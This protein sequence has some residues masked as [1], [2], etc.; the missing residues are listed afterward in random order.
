MEEFQKIISALLRGKTLRTP[1]VVSDDDGS[2]Y[3]SLQSKLD[4]YVRRLDSLKTQ[5]PITDWIKNHITF[6][7]SANALL[8]GSIEEY[9]TGNAGKAYDKIEE[10]M[11]C[12]LIQSNLVKLKTPLD[13]VYDDSNNSKSLY[14]VRYSD[15]PLTKREDIF[16]IPFEKR[17]LVDTQRFSIAGL[18]CLYLGSSLYV[19]WQEMGKPDLNKLYLSHYKINANN[20]YN[21]VNVLDFAYSLETL[22][23]EGL[24]EFVTFDED[25]SKEKLI[26]YLAMWPVLLACS[27][28]KKVDNSKFNVE[29]VIPNLIL[30]WIGKEKRPVSGIRYFSTKTT[31]LRHSDVGINYV[32][33]PSS[34]T[35]KT[36]G[37]CESL[38]R[39]F[40]FSRPVSWQ[41]LGA[42]DNQAKITNNERFVRSDNFEE[43]LVKKYKST[44]FFAM[45]QK[46]N[47]IME[48]SEIE[49]A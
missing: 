6:F 26:S 10:L 45:E 40:I 30:Q 20:S 1:F 41:I 39:T 46:L 47:D 33:P 28:N 43:Q 8:L 25:D 29:Y 3:A 12:D 48:C 36:K 4:E 9:L 14:R 22:K 11:R 21:N 49:Y 27:F 5:G 35:L 24:E 32:F 18:P 31:H 13:H 42:I 7:K 37:F 19:C 38:T 15:Y 44:Q 17:Y 23:H 16:H 2:Y 34:L